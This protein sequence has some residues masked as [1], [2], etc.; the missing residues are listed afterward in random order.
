MT[1]SPTPT[2]IVTDVWYSCYT[3][4]AFVEVSEMYEMLVLSRLR[5]DYF[6]VHSKTAYTARWY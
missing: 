3:I 2:P 1:L 6:T 4:K 5:K